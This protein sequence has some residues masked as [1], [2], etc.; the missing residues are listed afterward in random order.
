MH[1]RDIKSLT[2]ILSRERVPSLT[3]LSHFELFQL[4]TI[5]EIAPDNKAARHKASRGGGGHE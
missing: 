1:G 3:I 4:R 2:H 5:T